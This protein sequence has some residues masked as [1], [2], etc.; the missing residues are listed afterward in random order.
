MS[1]LIY[2]FRNLTSKEL[3]SF[4]ARLFTSLR[5]YSLNLNIYI[6]FPDTY[7]I[8]KYFRYLFKMCE[9]D[10][11]QNKVSQYLNLEGKR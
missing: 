6:Q 3:N 10:D 9:K 7:F 4:P 1:K 5:K 2:T 11:L 8:S